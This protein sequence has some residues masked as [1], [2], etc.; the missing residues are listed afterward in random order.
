MTSI[1]K[2]HNTDKNSHR[3]NNEWIEQLSEP[4]DPQSLTD[5]RQIIVRGLKPALY[6]YKDR[7]LEQF[8]EDVAQ[9]AL[10]KIL[11]NL[12]SFR[13][14]SKFTTWAMK[15]A[16]REGLSELRRKKWRDI[17]IQDLVYRY[18]NN[19][20]SGE[21]NNI[22]F[23]SDLSRP[24]EDAHENQILSRVLN[25]INHDLSKRQRTALLALKV[26]DVPITVVAD[27]MSVNR[28][29]LY[30]LVHDAR[31]KLKHSL[32]AAGIHSEELFYQT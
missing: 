8:T 25:I 19:D 30:K 1:A 31:K 29:A 2:K 16:I 15:I 11:E 24:D 4:L 32:H 18:S 12:D 3:A 27:Q 22:Q 28:N 17:S 26:E 9:D 10:L 20:K 13:G 5:L 14:D 21:I 6:K 7:E 23:T